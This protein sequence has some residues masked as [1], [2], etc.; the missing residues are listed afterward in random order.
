MLLRPRRSARDGSHPIDR[1]ALAGPFLERGNVGVGHFD[2]AFDREEERDVDIDAFRQ[3]L[4]D[5]RQ[6]FLGARDL[7]EK[8]RDRR[9]RVEILRRG[10]RARRVVR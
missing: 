7:D 6:T 3:A 5:R 4:L 1:L 10:E 9:S 8:V 2:I